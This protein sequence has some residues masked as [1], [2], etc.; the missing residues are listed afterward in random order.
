MNEVKTPKKPLLYYY[1]IVLLVLLLFNFL[2]MPWIAQNQIVDVDYNTFIEMT[3]NGEISRAELQDA[4]N[5]ILFT[6]TNEK[7]VYKTAMVDD[8]DLISRLNDNGVSFRGEEIEQ[9]SGFLSALLSWVLPMVIF[10]RLNH[11]RKTDC[12]S[13]N[14][15]VRPPRVGKRY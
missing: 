8:P 15:A 13:W 5:R 3:E 7:I 11:I 6:D 12:R 1:V 14:R 2:A 9:S 10:I 4:T